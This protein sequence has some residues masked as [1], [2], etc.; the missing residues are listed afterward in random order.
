[1]GDLR[2]LRK[3]YLGGVHWF[4]SGSPAPKRF[5]VKLAGG[6]TPEHITSTIPDP[7]GSGSMKV[8]VRGNN[9]AEMRDTAKAV[10][11]MGGKPA[12]RP[13]KFRIGA[14]EAQEYRGGKLQKV[15][16]TQ[17]RLEKALAEA[18]KSTGPFTAVHRDRKVL[19]RNK[20]T[21]KST[22]RDRRNRF[23]WDMGTKSLSIRGLKAVRSA[24]KLGVLASSR[25]LGIGSQFFN[26]GSLA[27]ATK[28]ATQKKGS[29]LDRF[30]GLVEESQGVKFVDPDVR[31]TLKDRI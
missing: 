10:K 21:G 16:L 29:W 23:R 14:V 27:G 5:S 6:F 4:E 19:V 30:T 11:E 2:V 7:E 20:K 24:G 15:R 26:V 13:S 8:A 18:E 12:F 9:P 25:A 22:L 28:R 31:K 17:S 3:P 1:L